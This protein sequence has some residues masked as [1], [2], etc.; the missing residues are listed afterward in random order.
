MSDPLDT[1]IPG[2]DDR[3][4]AYHAMTIASDQTVVSDVSIP[5][6]DDEQAIGMAKQLVNGHAVELW[7][8]LR[9]IE[10]FE[11]IAAES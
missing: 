9:F 8:R 6:D 3:P 7:D 4:P 10:R 11:P 1:R 5:A 2:T